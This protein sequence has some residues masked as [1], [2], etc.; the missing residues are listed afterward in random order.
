MYYVRVYH[1]ISR[2]SAWEGMEVLRIWETTQEGLPSVLKIQG[3]K[4]PAATGT[5]TLLR[6]VE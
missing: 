3:I 5:D 6:S 4:I 1:R 2:K